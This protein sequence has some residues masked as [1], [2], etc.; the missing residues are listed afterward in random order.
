MLYEKSIIKSVYEKTITKK[1]GTSFTQTILQLEDKNSNGSSKLI[2]YQ[3]SKNLLDN[4]KD[5]VKEYQNLVDSS[6]FVPVYKISDPK[7]VN[8]ILYKNQGNYVAGSPLIFSS[9]NA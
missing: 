8:G 1:D 6:A 9:E 2:E 3:F 7:I 4:N 5:I